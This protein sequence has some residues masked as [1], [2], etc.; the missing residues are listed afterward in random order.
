ML[1][2][3]I[4]KFPLWTASFILIFLVS[5]Y[6][7][8]LASDRYVSEANVV[9]ESPQLAPPELS[10]S[11]LFSG[12]SAGTNDMLLLRDYLLSVDM[13]REVE[14]RMNFRQH[15]SDTKIDFFS[16]LYDKEAYLEEVHQYFLKM[17]SVE[18]D[19]YAQVLR[20][21]VRAFSPEMA[22][23][24]ASFLLERGER[25]MNLMGQRL[26]EE[27]VR[28]LEKQVKQ[29]NERFTASRQELLDYQNIKGLVSPAGTVESLNAVV[30]GLEAQLT[31]L[32][33]KR[34]TLTSFQSETSP[35]V[36]RITTE[37]RS[38]TEQIEQ[39][40]SRMAQQS[41]DALN[42][43]SSE[44]R[45]LELKVQFAQESYSGALAAL[46]NTRI[47]AAR[48]L[49]QVSVLQSP[50]LPEYPVEPERLHNSIMFTVVV[51]FLS[52]I[53]HMLMLIVKEHR[54]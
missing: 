51:M 16:R 36:V 47:E 17:V 42:V 39:E 11:S 4:K 19:D 41:G 53:G 25:H 35:E 37:I 21:K 23:D 15:F 40:R 45:T 48:K 26:A 49:K 1:K 29:L 7:L 44:Y 27:Q 31:D 9:L 54:D 5:V 30:A 43:V 8:F 13:L 52:L 22:K 6:W 38:L 12:G 14:Q 24:I 34:S 50:T 20:I 33:A 46:E 10:F 18:L 32:K 3:T 28:F 2:Q